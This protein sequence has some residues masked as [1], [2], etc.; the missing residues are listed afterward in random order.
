MDRQ[1]FGVGGNAGVEIE[2]ERSTGGSV[3]RE[4]GWKGETGYV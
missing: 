3:E 2:E 1:G 4:E